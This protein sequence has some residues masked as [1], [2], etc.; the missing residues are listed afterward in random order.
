MPQNLFFSLIS[1]QN[2]LILTI[3][4]HHYNLNIRRLFKWVEYNMHTL[5]IHPQIIA[6]KSA[7]CLNFLTFLAFYN[8][9]NVFQPETLSEVV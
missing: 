7:F 4:L 8:I 1:E 5:S 2:V 9:S 6:L 3:Q